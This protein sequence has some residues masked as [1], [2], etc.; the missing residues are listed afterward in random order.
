[1]R[2]I[3][4]EALRKLYL[5]CTHRS[6]FPGRMPTGVDNNDNEV[7]AHAILQGLGLVTTSPDDVFSLE[8]EAP[9]RDNQHTVGKKQHRAQSLAIHRRPIA[10]PICQFLHR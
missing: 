3:T 9:A 4:N 1:M 6:G 7:S 2:D 10:E 5:A 8:R